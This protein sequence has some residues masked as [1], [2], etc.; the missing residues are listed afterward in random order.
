MSNNPPLELKLLFETALKQFEKKAGTNLMQHQVFHKLE[1]CESVDS[2]I[3]VLQKQAEAFNNYR[4][5]D[6]KLMTW[7]KRT[8]G[9]VHTLSTSGVLGGAINLGLVGVHF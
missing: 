6:G 9:V 4:G 5:D 1:N 7:L 8:V 3:D 2:V